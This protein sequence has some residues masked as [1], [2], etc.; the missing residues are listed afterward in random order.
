MNNILLVVVDCARAEKTVLDLPGASAGTRRSAPLPTLDGL[1]ARGTTWTGYHTVS[2]TTTPNFAT[3]WTGLLP[4]QHGI[5]EHSRHGLLADVPTLAEYLRRAGYTTSAQVT[6]PLLA[7]TGLDRGFDEYRHRPRTEYLHAG[8]QSSACRW[9][10]Q[11]PEPWFACLHLWE[12]HL[13]Y[14]DGGPFADARFGITP[15]DRALAA[16]DAALAP[17]LAS[18]PAGRTSLVFCGDHGERLAEDYQLDRELGGTSWPLYE[19]RQVFDR[20]STGQIDYDAWFARLAAEFGDATARIYAHNVLGHGFHLTEDLVRAPLVIVDGR[21]PPG[22]VR[23]ELRSQLDLFATLLDLAGVPAPDEHPRPGR[24]LLARG[25]D[26]WVYLE[27]NG[28]GGKQFASRCYLRGAKSQ[29]WKYW[30]LETSDADPGH[31]PEVL[32]HLALDP[33]ETRDVAADEPE[34]CREMRSWIAAARSSGPC[35]ALVADD[36]AGPLV[37]SH[38]RALGYLA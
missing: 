9:L 37:E 22:E 16:V 18:V 25:G 31:E 38:L 23:S 20:E 5:R 13:P 33:R 27:A 24:S 12:A 34:R 7:E 35:P 8:F 6:G 21:C 11:L 1:R 3:M 17:V 30:Y 2:S 4:D 15:Y 26:P 10:A 36:A 14:Q 29:D 19:R 28:S 32:W